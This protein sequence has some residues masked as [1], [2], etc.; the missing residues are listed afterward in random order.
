[1]VGRRAGGRGWWAE[2][3]DVGRGG[4]LGAWGRGE[5]GSRAPP[6]APRTA[7][8]PRVFRLATPRTI[9]SPF[10]GSRDLGELRALP[11]GGRGG[12]RRAARG[13]SGLIFGLVVAMLLETELG[14]DRDRPGAPGAAA[15]CTVGGTRG[16]D[17]REPLGLQPEQEH[18]QGEKRQG[19]Q[20]QAEGQ[21]GGRGPGQQRTEGALQA[22]LGRKG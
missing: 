10:R 6:S 15:V 4:E 12:G 18:P 16:K 9:G 1:M 11:R 19:W 21:R 5:V 2:L 8:G 7:P 17:P 20:S 3:E 22:L 13:H 14:R